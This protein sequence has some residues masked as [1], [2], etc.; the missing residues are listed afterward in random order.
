MR[1]AKSFHLR[2]TKDTLQQQKLELEDD[3]GSVCKQRAARDTQARMR[4]NTKHTTE[5]T[6]P[7]LVLPTFEAEGD[8][9]I[10]LKEFTAAKSV[11]I[12]ST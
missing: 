1:T 3:I 5:R 12:F 10:T 7:K 6:S 9:H 4:S 8:T 11:Q 2:S